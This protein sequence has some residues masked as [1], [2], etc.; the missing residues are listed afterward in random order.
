[1]SLI[2]ICVDA[3]LAAKIAAKVSPAF[4]CKIKQGKSLSINTG[5]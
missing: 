4:P 3:T 1:M 2:I 5:H